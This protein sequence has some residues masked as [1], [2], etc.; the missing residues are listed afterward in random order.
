MLEIHGGDVWLLGKPTN[1][2]DFSSNTNPLGPPSIVKSIL[3]EAVEEEYYQ[4][5]PEI[6]YRR[7][8]TVITDFVKSV[9]GVD[10]QYGQV[11]VFNGASECLYRVFDVLKPSRILLLKPSYSTYWYLAK[12][13]GVE[14]VCVNYRFNGSKITI[15]YSELIN[16]AR[17]VGRAGKGLIIICNPNNP[18]GTF[19]DLDVI[20]E[21]L[22]ANS[23]GFVLVDE[24]F[25][26]F[27]SRD[28][29]IKL[30]RSYSNLVIVKSL[31][32]IFATPGLRLGICLAGEDFIEKLSL[33]SPPWRVGTLS[34][35][36]YC[37]LL[38]SI[39]Y[40]KNY[41][42]KTRMY[43]AYE[44]PLIARSLIDLGLNVYSSE[45]HFMLI[46]LNGLVKSYKLKSRLLREFNILIRDA[47]TIP[48]LTD[49]YIR[50]SLRNHRDNIVLV[51]C[52]RRVLSGE[53]S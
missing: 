29:A 48:G 5:Y 16:Y 38:S 40:V 34:M 49:N 51:E 1:I 19:I 33:T 39:D 32:K 6:T 2:L 8:K 30:L 35:L 52:L 47:S 17:W 10:L 7:L 42:S 12:L 53:V 22:K 14:T 46:S 43:V 28:S 9:Y 31:T 50:I 3:R 25:I 45:T 20:E 44:R 36:A 21:T 24:S 4:Y 37:K 13:Y 11:E 41:I 18:T 27:T 15:D 26:D 23:D